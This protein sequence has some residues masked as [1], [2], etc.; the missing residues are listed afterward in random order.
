MQ[1]IDYNSITDNIVSYLKSVNTTT[2]AYDLS[3][4]LTHRIGNISRDDL[5]IAPKFKSL[6]PSVSVRL[7]SKTEEL[8]D[9]NS[10]KIGRQISLNYKIYAIYDSFDYNVTNYVLT[11]IRN[12]EVNMRAYPTLNNYKTT[13]DILYCTP[14]NMQQIQIN[15]D[16]MKFNQSASIDINI[17]GY[18]DGVDE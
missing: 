7:D 9:F 11:L 16:D 8:E 5:F 13:L 12:I 2:A 15:K 6:Y 14:G 1:H 10:N 18:L 17:M 4:G 3:L